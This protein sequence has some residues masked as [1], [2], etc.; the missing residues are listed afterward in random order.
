MELLI[1]S[2]SLEYL[3][4]SSRCLTFLLF[5][6]FFSSVRTPIPNLFDFH[7]ANT[8]AALPIGLDQYVLISTLN[9]HCANTFAECSICSFQ[10]NIWNEA[11]V[12]FYFTLIFQPW[13]WLDVLACS[14]VFTVSLVLHCFQAT[15]T[16][17]L[18]S[19]ACQGCE[20][21][22]LAGGEGWYETRGSR[23]FWQPC[24]VHAMA[25]ITRV[26]RIERGC[27]NLEMYNSLQHVIVLIIKTGPNY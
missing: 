8:V 23:G 5:S 7:S 4:A 10:C 26:E 25:F 12:S 27:W 3:K 1:L 19:L 20:E 17:S 24:L 2:E 15:R 18:Q 9:I 11:T 16:L 21:E 22:N 6:F 13:R 14:F